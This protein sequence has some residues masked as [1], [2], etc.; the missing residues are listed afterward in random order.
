M[1]RTPTPDSLAYEIKQLREQLARPDF[2]KRI[3]RLEA[4]ADEK[5]LPY[6]RDTGAK[7]DT[8]S[9]NLIRLNTR[10]DEAAKTVKE[11]RDDIRRELA[12]HDTRLLTIEDKS[13]RHTVRLDTLED[14]L[15]NGV[16]TNPTS[17]TTK[18]LPEPNTH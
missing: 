16:T 5:L 10:F 4:V 11:W 15:A 8:V 17:H 18:G 12:E 6:I 3:E 14:N 1:G 9:E 13:T 7:Y 2:V